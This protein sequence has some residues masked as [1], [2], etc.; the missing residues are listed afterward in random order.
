MSAVRCFD[1]LTDFSPTEPRF[2]VLKKMRDFGPDVDPIE[3]R[4]LN[5]LLFDQ[6]FV[7][8][9]CAGWYGDHPMGPLTA[10]EVLGV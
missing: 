9:G 7:C 3:A 10:D 8:A 4:Q 1:C 6:V 5:S 2:A